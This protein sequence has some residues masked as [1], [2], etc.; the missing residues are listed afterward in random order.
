MYVRKRHVEMLRSLKEGKKPRGVEFLELYIQGFI[1]KDGKLTE[2]GEII[3]TLEPSE[4]L[5]IASDTVKEAELYT[6]TGF[7]PEEWQ[8]DILSRGLSLEDLPKIWEAYEKAKPVIMLTPYV[9]SFIEEIP[10]AGNYDELIKF[11]DAKNYGQNVINALQAMRLLFVS[12]PKNGRRTYAL[13]GGARR[14]PEFA[15]SLTETVFLGEEEMEKLR[16]EMADENLIRYGLQEASGKLTES[17]RR[18]LE[19]FTR[20]EEYV[21]PVYLGEDEYQTLKKLKEWQEKYSDEKDRIRKVKKEIP[22]EILRL[23][24][25]RGFIDRDYRVTPDGERALS[26]GPTTVDGM[27]A[28]VFSYIGDP[29][30]YD[31]ME[32]AKEEGL[33]HWWITSKAEFF[34]EI[35]RKAIQFPYL[36]KYDVAILAKIPRRKYVTLRELKDY[37]EERVGR[38][39]RAVGEAETKGLVR[40]FQNDA[41]RLTEFGEKMKEIVEYANLPELLNTSLAI[42]PETWRIIRVLYGNEEEVN[43]IWK[44]ADENKKDY[45]TELA[46]WVA[47]EVKMDEEEVL[48]FMK[49]LHLTGFL[50]QKY[51]TEAGRKL[52]EVLDVRVEGS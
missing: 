32:K 50:G 19:A 38:Y 43:Y 27:R 40:V 11:R 31:W 2:A 39:D 13:S 36:T 6:K 51:L 20:K 26:F 4:E 46:K 48:K 25:F 10:P 35:G 28:V 34:L 9:I 30:A 17:G 47:K 44:K 23:L 52:A 42:T 22:G 45:Y 12:P 41:V 29:P 24:E 49:L 15:L 7:I 37:V 14:I 5:F 18:V 3:S 8:R 16:S 1:T 33:F 21:R